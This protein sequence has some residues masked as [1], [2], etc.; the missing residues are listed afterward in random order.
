MSITGDVK[1]KIVLSILNTFAKTGAGLTQVNKEYENQTGEKLAPSKQEG[2]IYM[3][4]IGEEVAVDMFGRYW[5]RSEKS[6]HILKMVSEQNTKFSP[7]YRGNTRMFNKIFN[8]PFGTQRP[9]V[10]Y[11]N[12]YVDV[13][14][15]PRASKIKSRRMTCGPFNVHSSSSETEQK[16]RRSV[17]PDRGRASKRL[18]SR[19][20]DRT[21]RSPDGHR[22]RARSRSPPKWP[23]RSRS[24][25]PPKRTGRSISPR[26]SP[27]RSP[28]KDKFS[29]DPRIKRTN[30][31]TDNKPNNTRA[32]RSPQRCRQQNSRSP[33]RWPTSNARA[34]VPIDAENTEKKSL[35]NEE[36]SQSTPTNDTKLQ[37][38]TKKFK[39]TIIGDGYMYYMLSDMQSDVKFNLSMCNHTLTIGDA[40]K[41]IDV[42]H[43]TLQKKKRKV[44]I[45]IGV[46]DLRNG[47]TLCEMK[48]DFTALFLRCDHYGLKP[49]I[50]TILCFDLP[51][52]KTKADLF[53]SFL[54]DCFE[55]VVDM[56]MVLRSGLAD[57]TTALNKKHAMK[58][59]QNSLG[60]GT[61][62]ELILNVPKE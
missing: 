42:Q 15:V 5:S 53:N 58:L 33:I 45:A 7:N 44:M 18:R 4:S 19:S 23:G 20:R 2:E 6:A 13:N 11:R 54:V 40:L 17:T 12:D 50:T 9:T 39:F 14:I 61:R 37:A 30:S 8:H 62:Q 31:P 21:R 38:K 52:L 49:L 34:N 59:H 27:R 60:L 36:K 41:M 35:K 29:V 47:R 46:T 16:K 57:V 3:R 25:S 55:N 1:K 26:Y 56:R 10:S 32:A 48:R 28:V 24:R 43:Q 22:G 51:E